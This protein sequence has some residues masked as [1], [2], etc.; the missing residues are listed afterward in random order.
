MGE[1]Y[2]VVVLT[3]VGRVV[4][5]LGLFFLQ[6]SHYLLDILDTKFDIECPRT[7]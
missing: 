4:A 2:P 6:E 3:M 7:R 1:L 5:H